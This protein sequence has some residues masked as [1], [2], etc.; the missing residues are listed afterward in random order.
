MTFRQFLD[1]LNNKSSNLRWVNNSK[2]MLNR[3]FGRKIDKKI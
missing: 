2:N 3:V 1:K